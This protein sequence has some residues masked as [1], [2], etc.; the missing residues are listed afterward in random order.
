MR[1][2]DHGTN[3]FAPA[4]S[5]YAARSAT[6][7]LLATI[8]VVAGLSV[9]A[10]AQPAA[11]AVPYTDAQA[12]AGLSAYTNLC[13]NCHGDRLNGG[14]GGGPPIVGKD[15]FDHWGNKPI[16]EVF[17]FIKTNMPADTPNTLTRSQVASILAYILKFNGLPAGETALPIAE[18]D[19]AAITL[20]KP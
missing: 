20:A 15:F 8:V 4:V 3:E 6:G 14:V 1:G 18:A 7:G 12:T 9:S 16:A 13:E 19:L 10:L 5:G 17:A 11:T 2:Q